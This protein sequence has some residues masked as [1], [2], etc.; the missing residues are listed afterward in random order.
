MVRCHECGSDVAEI[1][2]FCPFCGVR[3]Q[4]A[5]TAAPERSAPS[6]SG[7]REDEAN[8]TTER[9]IFGMPII[10]EIVD[11][12][13]R[14]SDSVKVEATSEY[15]IPEP[16]DEPEGDASAEA[17]APEGVSRA[18]AAS[19]GIDTAFSEPPVIAE[20]GIARPMEDLEPHEPPQSMFDSVR[21]MES[22][23]R[24]DEV[25]TRIQGISGGLPEPPVPS[26]L[27]EA[28]NV[29]AKSDTTSGVRG[30][31]E[32]DGRRAKLKPL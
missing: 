22:K 19:D 8:A 4:A 31:G 18:A 1:D 9:D 28:T 11:D 29:E 2:V 12:S 5:E 13:G 3:M 27:S 14:T 30:T 17:E 7:D 15:K 25:D 26:V 21:I 24:P 32:T 23:P 16:Y 6:A 10:P 20:P